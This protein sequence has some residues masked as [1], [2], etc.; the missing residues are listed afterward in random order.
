MYD[1]LNIGLRYSDTFFLSMFLQ[2]EDDAKKNRIVTLLLPSHDI[3][4][5]KLKMYVINKYECS[6]AGQFIAVVF[7]NGSYQIVAQFPYQRRGNCRFVM[8]AGI[9]NENQ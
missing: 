2:E 6:T 7:A 5:Q 1:L 4:F 8:S 9:R 3:Y